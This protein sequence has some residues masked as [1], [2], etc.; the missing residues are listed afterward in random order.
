MALKGPSNEDIQKLHGEVNQIVSQ[1]LSLTVFAVSLLGV[2]I[3][4]VIPPEKPKEPEELGL[5]V[6]AVSGLLSIVLLCLFLLSFSLTSMLRTLTTYL[7]VTCKSGWEKD[8]RKYRTK[9]RDYWAYTRPQSMVFVLLGC[10]SAAFPIVL[11]ISFEYN[12]QLS[13]GFLIA[14]AVGL[15]CVGLEFLF[16]FLPRYSSDDKSRA[17]WEALSTAEEDALT[18]GPCD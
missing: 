5:F 3:A 2:C 12:F 11:S 14:I 15:A 16:A 1:R 10:L 6:Y 18:G 4:W 9:Y 7:D 8:W 13:F 17:R